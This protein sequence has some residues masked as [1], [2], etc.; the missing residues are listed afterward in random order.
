MN[1]QCSNFL[2]KRGFPSVVRADLGNLA[3]SFSH[4]QRIGK[5]IVG[6][7]SSFLTSAM[8]TAPQLSDN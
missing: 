3:A 8:P 1:K 5:K 2:N 6:V 4:H 7:I